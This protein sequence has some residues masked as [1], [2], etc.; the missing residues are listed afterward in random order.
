M[1]GPQSAA[2]KPPFVITKALRPASPSAQRRQQLNSGFVR[3]APTIATGSSLLRGAI[4]PRLVKDYPYC[5]FGPFLRDKN[6]Q[7]VEN[8]LFIFIP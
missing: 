3:G 6:L 8:R 1:Y 4:P 5:N 7:I 2:T